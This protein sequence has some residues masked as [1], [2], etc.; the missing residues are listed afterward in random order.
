MEKEINK[1]SVS[2]RGKA[3]DYLFRGVMCLLYGKKAGETALEKVARLGVII[4]TLVAL[5]FVF[6]AAKKALF[7]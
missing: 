3:S 2:W 4:I 5:I 1:K 7:P 6:S